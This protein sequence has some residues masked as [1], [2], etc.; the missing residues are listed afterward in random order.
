MTVVIKKGMS[1]SQIDARLKK[2]KGKDKGFPAH[3]FT[4]KLKVEESPLTIQK[5]LRDE[6]D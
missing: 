6:W 2:L 3:K 1:K 5:R 4:G